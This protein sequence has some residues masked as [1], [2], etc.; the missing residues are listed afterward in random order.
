MKKRIY[1]F[2]VI[3]LLSLFITSTYSCTKKTGCAINEKAHVKS[4]KDGN[5]K[6]KKAKSGLF[7]KN[8]GR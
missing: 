6:K 4:D 7:P 3:I 1:Q 8:M 5:F 2:G